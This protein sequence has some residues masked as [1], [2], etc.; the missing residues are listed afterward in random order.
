M[1]IAGSAANASD[2]SLCDVHAWKRGVL[3]VKQGNASPTDALREGWMANEI[4]G[5]A[6]D[7]VESASKC[8]EQAQ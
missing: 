2:T 8:A 5:S 7:I 6:R 3:G 1:S 4:F